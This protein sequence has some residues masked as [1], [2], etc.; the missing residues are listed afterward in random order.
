M[1][2]GAGVDPLAPRDGAAP[3]RSGPATADPG[4]ADP[5]MADPGMADP[6]MADLVFAVRGV[7]LPADYRH[8][9]WTALCGAAPWLRD[10]PRVGVQGVRSVPTGGASVLLAHRARLTLRLPAARLAQAAAALEG[11]RIDIAGAALEIGASHVR[12]LAAAATLYAEFVSTGS[13]HELAFR[14]EVATALQQLGVGAGLVCGGARALAV[15]G[16]TVHGFA[17]AL[18]GLDAGGALKLLCAG[19]GRH[20]ELGCGF[21]VP[22]KTIVGVG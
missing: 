16:R 18:H 10:E 2:P 19:L 21:F 3:L 9:L 5:G 14:D 6:G 1:N 11:R 20:R 17:L 8:A 12:P 22:Y 13:A 7:E 15:D 4:M